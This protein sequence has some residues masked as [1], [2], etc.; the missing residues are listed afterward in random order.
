MNQRHPT[1]HLFTV[2]IWE[3]DLG[4]G[5]IEWRGGLRHVLS[6]D[7]RYFRDWPA[8]VAHLREML[9]ELDE[10]AGEDG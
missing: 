2:R 4:G 6:G 7:T 8:L 3:E 1:T 5:Q 10:E 9:G